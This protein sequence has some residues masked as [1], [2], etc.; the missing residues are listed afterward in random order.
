[1]DSS[2]GLGASVRLLA[3]ASHLGAEIHLAKL[4]VPSSL[5]RWAQVRGRS[6]W[7][8]AVTGGEDYELIFTVRPVLWAQVKRRI[9]GVTRIGQMFPHGHGIW[10]V[11]PQG[12]Q[13]L[14]GYGFA[15]FGV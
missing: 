6:A 4:P 11:T 1:M 3:E 10:A 7:D 8:Y 14:K 2:D 5:A 9:P 12:R 13:S 15:H